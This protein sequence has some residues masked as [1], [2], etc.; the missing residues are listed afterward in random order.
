MVIAL[1]TL[2]VMRSFLM[3]VPK[4]LPPGESGYRS[5][6]AD[7][8]IFAVLD[9]PSYSVVPGLRQACRA[10]L[11]EPAVV[12]DEREP[13]AYWEG[14]WLASHK[15]RVVSSGTAEG[16]QKLLGECIN[17]VAGDL[18]LVLPP[19]RQV[20]LLTTRLRNPAALFCSSDLRRL[21]Q[22]PLTAAAG[23]C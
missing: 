8:E 20:V 22:P 21:G 23:A 1:L 14:Y 6:R 17:Q 3:N 7:M 18:P 9:W 13:A 15:P 16:W 4:A 5:V 11:A 19:I 10:L 2:P 12:D